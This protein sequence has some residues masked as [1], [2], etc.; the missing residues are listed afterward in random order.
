MIG[1]AI[2]TGGVAPESAL[3]FALIFMWTPP[4][5]WALSLFMND[6]YSRAGVP[7]MTVARGKPYTRK[8]VLIYTAILIP[9]ALLL[10][11][12]TI[13]GALYLAVA[14]ALNAWLLIGA[15]GI[16][17]RTDGDAEADK[18]RAEKR[19]FAFSILYLFLHFGALLIEAGLRA[20][21]WAAQL[22]QVL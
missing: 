16:A 11:F 2:A 9:V 3:M 8:L 12:T 4:H 5:F 6:D 14:L 20:I 15:L 19:F 18:Y 7:M 13:G 17:R 22:P 10:A 1:W 21:G